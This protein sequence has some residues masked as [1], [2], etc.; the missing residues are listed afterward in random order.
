MPVKCSCLLEIVTRWL[1]CTNLA[2]MKE[3]HALLTTRNKIYTC[4]RQP[5]VHV[6]VYVWMQVYVYFSM[7]TEVRGQAQMSVL[8]LWMSICLSV[9]LW[10]CLSFWNGASCSG[11]SPVSTSQS[12]IGILTL[13]MFKP[14]FRTPGPFG[15]VLGIHTRVL[16]FSQQ[17]LLPTEPSL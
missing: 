11:D 17:G 8:Q 16:G 14:H 13:Q 7:Y 1:I 5:T 2:H 9:C 3:L 10:H 6:C 12:C 15:W 4:L